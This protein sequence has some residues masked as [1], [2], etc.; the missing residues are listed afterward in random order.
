MLA[1]K[2]IPAT[3]L[4][5]ASLPRKECHSF[6]VFCEQITLALSQNLDEPSKHVCHVYFQTS[7]FISFVVAI[8]SKSN[9]K[10]GLVDNERMVGLNLALGIHFSLLCTSVQ[11][12][13][14][15]YRKRNYDAPVM[16]TQTLFGH[17]SA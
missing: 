17:Y 3:N 15:M 16:S 4:L 6:L 14:Y 5:L 13:A 11:D 7:S 8:D 9:M 10:V 1:T 2:L 12:T